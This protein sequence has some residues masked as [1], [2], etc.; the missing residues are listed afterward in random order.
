LLEVLL[1][2]FARQARHLVERAGLFEKMGGPGYDH[3]PLFAAKFGQRLP[4]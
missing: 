1:E 4:V 2:P 3:Q